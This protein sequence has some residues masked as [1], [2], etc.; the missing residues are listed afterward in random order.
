M[1]GKKQN[2][3]SKAPKPTKQDK[4]AQE[5][6]HAPEAEEIQETAEPEEK[7][8]PKPERKP[9]TKTKTKKESK[10]EAVDP[11]AEEEETEAEL[12]EGK[13]KNTPDSMANVRLQRAR[14]RIWLDLRDGIDLKALARMDAQAARDEVNSAV[15]EIA[16]FRNLDLTPAEL[17]S[18]AKECANDMLGFGPLEELLERDDI[19]D[20]MINGPDTTYIEVNGKIETANIEFR[21]NQHLTTICQRIVGA[22]GRRVDE[23]SPICDARLPDGSRVNVIIPPLSVDGACMT[24]RKFKKD[25][26][27]LDKLLEF[28]SMTPSCAKLIQAIGRCR[29]NVL[30]SGGTG[31]GKPQC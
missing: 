18:V 20:I 7:A 29:V 9:K 2:S 30:V 1:F 25:K 5:E 19:A 23:A 28:G 31:S 15:E 4:K 26:L 10:P 24:I 16:R 6:K 11:F 12:G 22:I 17:E 3:S 8:K 14:N 27:T 21:D 13:S